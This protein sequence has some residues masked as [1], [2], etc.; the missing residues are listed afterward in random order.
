MISS[1][2][3]NWWARHIVC[4]SENSVDQRV[5]VSSIGYYEFPP[6]SAKPLYINMMPII[7][8]K[9]DSI[10]EEYKHYIPLLSHMPINVQEWGNVGY[11]TIDERSVE[12]TR[13][14]RR[15]GLH[16]E[17]PPKLI[18]SQ[19]KGCD[20]Y[21]IQDRPPLTINWGRGEYAFDGACGIYKGGIYMLS[22]VSKST[23]VWNVQIKV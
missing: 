13:S 16:I 23:R 3:P 10:P 4:G 6:R 2:L 17:A 14:Q 18:P 12:E 9:P 8:G 15:P 22:D 20:A 5:F 1:Y 11:L 19:D 21:T 7:I